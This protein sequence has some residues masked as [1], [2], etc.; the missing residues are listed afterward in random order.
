MLAIRQFVQNSESHYLLVEAQSLRTKLVRAADYNCLQAD[1]VQSAQTYYAQILQRVTADS[2][3]LTNV[4]IQNFIQSAV[5]ISVDMC[6]SRRAYEKPLFDWLEQNNQPFAVAFTAGWAR[7]H[8]EEFQHLKSISEV[9]RNVTWVNHSYHH[10]YNR[11]MGLAGNF[12]LLPGVNIEQEVL[13][14]EIFMIENGLTPSVFFRFPGL[15]SSAELVAKLS[16][17]GLITLGSDAWLAKGE[18]PK[19]GSIIL[20]H[21]NGNEPRGIELFF[22]WLDQILSLGVA[23][24]PQ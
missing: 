21:G 4:G 19:A 11:D 13:G 18:R 9:N 2:E 6:P 16:E 23:A 8:A 12:L 20:L 1:P 17:W 22:R 3:R 15:V 14:N 5:V 10:P 7:R 24:L